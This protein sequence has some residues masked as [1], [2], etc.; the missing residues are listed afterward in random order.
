[1]DM[2]LPDAMRTGRDD[3]DEPLPPRDP[4]DDGSFTQSI[5]RRKQCRV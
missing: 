5:Y 2:C 1:M 4:P 3:S